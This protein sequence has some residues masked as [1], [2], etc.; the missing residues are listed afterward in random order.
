MSPLFECWIY[1]IIAA[2]IEACSFKDFVSTTNL[3]DITAFGG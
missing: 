3:H 1:E 2:V